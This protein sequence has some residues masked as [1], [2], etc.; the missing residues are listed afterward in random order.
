M[1]AAYREGQAAVKAEALVVAYELAER[2]TP[3]YAERDAYVLR[4]V[5]DLPDAR[6]RD[7]DNLAGGVLDALNG[8]LWRDD[9]HVVELRARKRL[10]CGEP[11]ASIEVSYA[12]STRC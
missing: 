7:I 8:L 10:R 1:P 5:F 12:R 11:G 4:V 9:T 3:W 2:G 6:R